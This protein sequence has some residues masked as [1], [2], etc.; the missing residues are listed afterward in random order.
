MNGAGILP[1]N[2]SHECRL[3]A[4]TTTPQPRNDQ[5]CGSGGDLAVKPPKEFDWVLVAVGLVRQTGLKLSFAPDCCI[6]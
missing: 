4:R 6:S 3:E 1:A 5:C 2:R